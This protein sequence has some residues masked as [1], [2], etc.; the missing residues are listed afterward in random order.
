MSVTIIKKGDAI[1]GATQGN[2]DSILNTLVKVTA[3]AKSLADFEK[4]YQTGQTRNG[5]MWKVPGQTGGLNDGSGKPNLDEV[6]VVPKENEGYVGVNNDH[7]SYV[8]FGTRN[9]ASQP[10]L[11]PAV[12][13]VVNGSSYKDSIRKIMIEQMERA[14]AAPDKVIQR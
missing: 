2:Q 1:K 7:A 8:E 13:I 6:S 14:M 11:R 12:D 4:G 5:I 10:Y 9:M 3:Q